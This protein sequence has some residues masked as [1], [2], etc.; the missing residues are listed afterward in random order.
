MALKSF[1]T[2]FASLMMISGAL[3]GYEGEGTIGGNGFSITSIRITDQGAKFAV[4]PAPAGCLGGTHWGEHFIVRFPQADAQGQ[5]NG[6]ESKKFDA[7]YS[8]LLTAYSA[9]QY[10]NGVWY[11]D[12]TQPCNTGPNGLLVVE[13]IKI[14]K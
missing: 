7:M 11:E 3:A 1:V 13:D 6:Q 5:L 12:R 9:G 8:A 2:C 14:A 4:S 10:L